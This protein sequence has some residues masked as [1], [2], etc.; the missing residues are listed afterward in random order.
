MQALGVKVIE[1]MSVSK[2][3]CMIEGIEPGMHEAY[4]S[5][6]IGKTNRKMK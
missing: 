1:A 2:K 3:H 6:L 5:S 4:I